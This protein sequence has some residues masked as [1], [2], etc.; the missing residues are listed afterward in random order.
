MRRRG[1]KVNEEKL[2]KHKFW[3]DGT[4]N[5]LSKEVIYEGWHNYR[6][7][8]QCL[9]NLQEKADCGG[10]SNEEWNKISKKFQKVLE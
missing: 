6:Y 10:I 5:E 3:K 9:F 8:R 2:W 7:L 4:V 1:Y